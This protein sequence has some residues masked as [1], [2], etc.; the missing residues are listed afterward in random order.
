VVGADGAAGG[1]GDLVQGAHASV[2]SEGKGQGH[3]I[4]QN[5]DMADGDAL[6][7]PDR[8]QIGHVCFVVI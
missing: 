5:L 7:A 3:A 1:I 4:I 2:S 6:E 8:P